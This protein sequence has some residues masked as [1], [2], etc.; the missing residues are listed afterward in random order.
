MPNVDLDGP[1][2]GG[3]DNTYFDYMSF[4]GTK[5]SRTYQ[6]VSFAWGEGIPDP[7]TD[8]H[9]FCASWTGQGEVST[10]TVHAFTTTANDEVRLSV[11]GKPPIEVG[12]WS[13]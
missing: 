7:G 3:L 9:T 11:G 8:P 1:R 6:T 4:T 10:S 2:V 13:H 12:A 5:I